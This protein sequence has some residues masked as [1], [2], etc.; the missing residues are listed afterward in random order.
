M[1]DFKI[2]IV[3]LFV[4]ATEALMKCPLERRRHETEF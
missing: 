3:D 2:N 4:N 1:L